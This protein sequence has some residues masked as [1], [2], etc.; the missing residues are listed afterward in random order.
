[1]KKGHSPLCVIAACLL[2]MTISCPKKNKTSVTI[3][4]ILDHNRMLLDAEIMRKD[5][6]W[7]KARLWVDTGNPDFFISGRLARDLGIDLP[8]EGKNAE[9][10]PP[11]GVRIGGMSL[12]FLGVKSAVLFEPAWLFSTMHNDANLPSTVLKQYR[13][14]FD[15]PAGRLTIAEP[16][17]FKP[18]GERVSAGVHMKT[19]IVQVDAVVDGDSLS[20]ALDN[21][22]SYSFMSGD[23]LEGLCS[24]NPGWPRSIGAAGC[25]N[26]WGWWP[27]E[28]SWPVVRIPEIRCGTV[29]MLGAGMVG[30]PAFFPAGKSLGDWYSMKALRPVA[31]F[32]GPNA[33]KAFRVEIDYAASAVYFEKGAAFDTLDMDLIGLT[34]RPDT[35]GGYRVIGVGYRDGKPAVQGIHAGDRLIQIDDFKTA[36]ATMGAVVD[37]LRGKPGDVRSLVLER[38]GRQ[39]RI[40]AKVE[41]L[42]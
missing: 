11:A 3:P 30:L 41:R 17:G 23:V 6:S 5:G 28:P 18:R 9:I 21:G 33:L 31:G 29:R 39:F 27:E 42:L 16:A 22:A 1:M 12:N 15:Y 26:I 25:A 13:I 7:R 20:F 37:A 2:L 38:N 40:E 8:A 32:L 14:V 4:F 24:R 34:L 10:A 19:G 36:G 35:D